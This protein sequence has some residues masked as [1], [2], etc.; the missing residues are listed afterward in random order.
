M[1]IIKAKPVSFAE[2]NAAF[3][4]DFSQPDTPRG[5]PPTNVDKAKYVLCSNLMR[6]P[7]DSSTNTNAAYIII[8]TSDLALPTARVNVLNV[9][10]ATQ[11]IV[12][13]SS[14]LFNPNPS[15]PDGTSQLN[16]VVRKGVGA[17]K[18]TNGNDITITSWTRT[19]ANRYTM[20]TSAAISGIAPNTKLFLGDIT[21]SLKSSTL[22]PHQQEL[23]VEKEPTDLIYGSNGINGNMSPAAGGRIVFTKINRIRID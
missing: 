2:R 13:S 18:D 11:Y 23:I 19:A 3:N 6:I 14:T 21:G 17:L 1:D 15:F 22:L 16:T 10:S 7:A 4:V 9:S 20:V 8:G 12:T 5:Q